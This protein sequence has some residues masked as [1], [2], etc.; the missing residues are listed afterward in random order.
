MNTWQTAAIGELV[1]PARTWN[2][3]SS[4]ADRRF[5]YIDL[6]AVDQET[7]TITGH[8]K[9]NCQ[10]APSRARQL[11]SEGDVL[12]ATVRPNLN[13]VARVP[14]M[15]HG[16]TAS[17]GFC[18][19]HPRPELL[20]SEYLLHWVKT[21]AFVGEM[22]RRA[23]GASYPAI[24]DRSVRES[25]IPFPPLPEQRR[26]AAMLDQ[27]DALRA[28]RRAAIAQLD[29]LAE[30]IFIDMFGDPGHT[31]E[32]FRWE[33]LGHSLRF[34]TSGSRGWAQY[35]SDAGDRFIRSLD[36]RMNAV[37]NEDSVYVNPP[38]NAEARRTRIETG[39]VL[40][41]ITGSR[42]GR[43]AAI[44][45]YLAGAYISQHVA[46][47]RLDAARLL[48]RY[49]SFFLSMRQGGRR[50]IEAAQYGQTKP[51]LNLEQIRRLGIPLPPIELQ[52]EFEQCID[53]VESTRK[54]H[55][56]SLAH[57]DSLFAS[58]QHRAFRGEL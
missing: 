17:T 45:S 53:A 50:Q 25:L 55:V 21:P 44:P 46:I 57:L 13:A 4:G 33:P 41:T 2:P 14:P 54:R 15:L 1:E 58:L 26:I 22:T 16:S 35:Y 9:V 42:I 38:D 20:D 48:P 8:R 12:V 30:S 6:S 56:C 24:T 29:T 27:A 37:S 31:H 39:D 18:V 23:T 43:V 19:L 3:A 7:K 10:E 34:V 52:L 51:G 40:L 28:K 36:V 47:L 11:V 32:H 49:L 5:Q